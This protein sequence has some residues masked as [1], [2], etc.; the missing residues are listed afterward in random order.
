[1]RFLEKENLNN[2]LIGIVIFLQ[3]ITISLVVLC[4]DCYGTKGDVNKDDNTD[5][6]KKKE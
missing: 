4:S 6:E 1:M 5:E 3:V 2:I